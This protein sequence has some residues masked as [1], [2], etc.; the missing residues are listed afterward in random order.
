MNKIHMYHTRALKDPNRVDFHSDP[1]WL[2][3][4]DKG[5][6][7]DVIIGDRTYSFEVDDSGRAVRVLSHPFPEQIKKLADEIRNRK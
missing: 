5:Y 2:V 7:T 6:I 3:R 1:A 4:N